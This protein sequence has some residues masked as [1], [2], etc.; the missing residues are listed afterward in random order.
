MTD[1]IENII[2]DEDWLETDPDQRIEIVEGEFIAEDE[3]S[4]TYLHVIVIDNLYDLLKLFVRTKQLGRVQ[5]DGIKYVLKR[6][7][8][9]IIV[10]RI[11]DLSFVRRERFPENFEWSGN[12]EGAPDLAVEVSSPGQTTQK[13]LEKIHD[14]LKYGSQEAWAIYPK[15]RELHRYQNNTTPPRI[16]H[17]GET[18]EVENLFPGLQIS[19]SDIFKLEA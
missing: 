2:T 9:K 14:Y 15:S 13:T 16:Y 17:E 19:V 5:T 7:G 12:F 6:E 18:F 10:G 8:K 4:M 1:K 11:P 3:E